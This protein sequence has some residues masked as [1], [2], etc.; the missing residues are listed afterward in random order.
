MFSQTRTETYQTDAPAQFRTLYAYTLT[1]KQHN[2]NARTDT[3]IIPA[4]N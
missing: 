3:R 1:E 2:Y 4:I